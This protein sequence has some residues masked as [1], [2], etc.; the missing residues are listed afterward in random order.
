MT[1]SACEVII[2]VKNK[3]VKFI[4]HEYGTKNILICLFVKI[5]SKISRSGENK[6]N[7][8]KNASD[9]ILMSQVLN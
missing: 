5:I 6:N 7:F 9:T 8:V 2:H 1:E 3:D 4:C